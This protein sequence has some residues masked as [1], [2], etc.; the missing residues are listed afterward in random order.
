MTHNQHI[1]KYAYADS[2][3]YVAW[4]EWAERMTKLGNRQKKCD[5]CGLFAIWYKPKDTSELSSKE[6]GNV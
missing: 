6:K 2:L 5:T 4:H 1:R 3:G